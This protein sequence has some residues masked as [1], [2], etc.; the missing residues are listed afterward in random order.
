MADGD[1]EGVGGVEG[2]ALLLAS[3]Q[4]EDHRSNLRFFGVAV[5]DEGLLDQPGLVLEDG[6]AGPRPR[7]GRRGRGR[8]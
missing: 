1:G 2:H 6:N 4:R 7:A 8:A 3:K 5:A